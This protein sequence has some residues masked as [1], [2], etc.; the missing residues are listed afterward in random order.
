MFMMIGKAKLWLL[1][2]EKSSSQRMSHQSECMPNAKSVF[3]DKVAQDE[4]SKTFEN[5]RNC[6]KEVNKMN[7]EE[8]YNLLPNSEIILPSENTTNL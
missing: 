6:G 2:F 3:K 1:A 8:E 7:S 4:R 5:H